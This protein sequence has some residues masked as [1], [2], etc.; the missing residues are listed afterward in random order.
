M[1]M[2]D[3]KRARNR[4]DQQR[5]LAQDTLDRYGTRIQDR[6]N[7]AVP[8]Y[9]NALNQARGDYS[10]IMGQYGGFARTGGFSPMD[11]ANMRGRAM[12]P[13]RGIF[14]AAQRDINRLGGPGRTAALSRLQRG[15][16][17]QMSDA[18][19]ATEANIAQLRQQGRL[20][21]LQG[22]SNMFGATP[23]MANMLRDQVNQT[24]SAMGHQAGLQN[25]LGLGLANAQISAAQIPGTFENWLNRGQQIGNI[26]G[27]FAGIP[28]INNLFKRGGGMPPSGTGEWTGY[29]PVTRG[30]QPF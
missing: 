23:G 17:Q 20:S 11:I 4:I 27:S 21:G 15:T 5:T 9:N 29:E 1:A 12:A 19:T 14:D 3:E 6:Y 2:G 10:N 22:M 24:T 13:S 18:A 30:S 26:A 7:E 25:Q 16:G 8:D 28:G